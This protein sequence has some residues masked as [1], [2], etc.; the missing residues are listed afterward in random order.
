[1][2]ALRQ[3]RR[4]AYAIG[5]T[6]LGM[7]T[8]NDLMRFRKDYMEIN[9]K[10]VDYANQIMDHLPLPTTHDGTPGTMRAKN[11]VPFSVLDPHPELR[12][13]SELLLTANA[14]RDA[15]R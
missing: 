8:H 4:S 9:K 10:V 13:L 6:Q 11:Q 15:T 2:A 12:A 5:V 14:G 7:I 1:M 3:R